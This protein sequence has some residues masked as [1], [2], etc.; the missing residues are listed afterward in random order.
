MKL[1]DPEAKKNISCGGKA[2]LFATPVIT[3]KGRKTKG[4]SAPIAMYGTCFMSPS[5]K[6]RVVSKKYENRSVET[7]S[8]VETNKQGSSARL[9]LC[10]AT[11]QVRGL[12]LK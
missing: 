4:G 6:L 2:A 12:R 5:S 1:R 9:I 8:T 3:R 7:T 11:Q 10:E